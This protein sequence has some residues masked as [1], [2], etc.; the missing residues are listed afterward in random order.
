MEAFEY[1]V[2]L[3]SLILG[4]GITQILTGVSDLVADWKKVQFSIT[5]GIYAVVVFIIHLQDWWYSYQYSLLIE[6]WKFVQVLGLLTFH[7]VLFLQARILFPTGSRAG[8]TDMIKYYGE[9]WRMLYG[10]G[11]ITVLIS[12]WQNVVFSNFP[13]FSFDLETGNLFQWIYFAI[14][15]GFIL[16]KTKNFY[17][18]VIFVTL[19]LVVWIGLVVNDPFVLK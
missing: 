5:H 11:S 2:V 12:I 9:N 4:L 6:E 13:V 10:L 16:S 1:F 18:H 17:A 7:I 15:I 14:Y 3:S 8:E 19:Q